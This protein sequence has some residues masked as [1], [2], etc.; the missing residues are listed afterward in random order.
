MFTFSDMRSIA[1]AKQI[2]T[3][4]V[5]LTAPV[6]CGT[7]TGKL[8]KVSEENKRLGLK[9][10]KEDK[11]EKY[12]DSLYNI[13]PPKEFSYIDESGKEVKI[14]ESTVD[15]K[16]GDVL[17]TFDLPNVLVTQRLKN[18]A[19]RNG[20]VNLDFIITVPKSL[21]DAKWQ[22]RVY[23]RAFKDNS[24]RIDLEPLVLSG[25]DF[26]KMQER[27]YAQY[28]AFISSIIPD[29]LY[30]KEMI[31]HKGV[32]KALS[33]L[34]AEYHNAW[35]K[36]ILVK[37]QW[38]DWRDRLNVRYKIFN[39]K[40]R[41]NRLSIDV[42]KNILA[43]LPE[44]WLE[45]TIDKRQVPKTFAEYAWG[46]KDIVKKEITDADRDEIEKRYTDIKRIAENE[47]KKQEKESMFNKLVKFPRMQ[48]RLDSIVEGNEDFQYYYT[49]QLDADSNTKKIRL[50]LDGEVVAIDMSTF[51]VPSSDTLTYYVSAMVD[52]LDES[53][54][55]K[56]EVVYR[57]VNKELS[58]KINFAQ[59]SAV[60]N[61]NMGENAQEFEKIKNVIYDLQE[62]G[63][64]VLDS[65]RMTGYSSP[66]G[67]ANFNNKLSKRRTDA[68]KEYLI[69]HKFFGK[70]TPP[71]RTTNGGENWRGID[72][73]LQD[74]TRHGYS[75][76]Q[77]ANIQTLL[78]KYS[79]EDA[80]E[81]ALKREM[82]EVYNKLKEEVY[83]ELRE[84]VFV[85]LTHRAEMA[86]D[87]VHTTVL[88]TEYDKGRDLLRNRQ[89]KE[90]LEL[91]SA[92]PR[93]INYA[94]CL[95]SLSY[96]KPALDILEQYYSKKEN[97]DIDYLKAILYIRLGD[98]GKSIRHLNK[99][100]SLDTRKIFRAQMDPELNKL[101]TQY[102]LF[103]E[104][105]DL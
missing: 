73:W 30:W 98:V 95:M 100:A 35:R 60:V 92:Y 64:L 93:D 86:K 4:L 71:I 13:A 103:S 90:A 49:Q 17:P 66:E 81:Q 8:E 11:T 96:D 77:K 91:L 23:P 42:E 75:E 63:D 94:I 19:E 97:A 16:T 50:V 82:P 28:K 29:S 24:E 67:S 32:A 51:D 102:N 12:I 84:T 61:P 78:N 3:F 41:R 14:V 10:A 54:R 9:F 101:I 39:D 89:Y 65:L 87:T 56:T 7:M 34:E 38:I 20:M 25:A 69:S 1:K 46:N 53:P 43:I 26:L 44:Y 85:F 72:V 88:D 40:M 36:D 55:Y 5:L 99:A 58:A 57:Q 37:N 62:I 18:I 76:M 22:L 52:F 47:R 80:R 59:G 68:L 33:D 48:A 83:P 21:I 6:A 104:Y 105:L 79:D 70:T 2:L 27:G 31:D 74:S 45:R 15:E